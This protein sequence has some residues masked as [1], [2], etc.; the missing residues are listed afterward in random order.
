MHKGPRGH[1]AAASETNPCPPS[2]GNSL[3]YDALHTTWSC[4]HESVVLDI[5]HAHLPPE[6]VRCPAFL[7]LSASLYLWLCLSR[8]APSCVPFRP[9]RPAADKEKETE[10]PPLP[11]LPELPSVAAGGRKSAGGGGGGGGVGGG[12]GGG[13]AVDERRTSLEEM[14]AR[15]EQLTALKSPEHPD[16]GGTGGG[17]ADRGTDD[18]DDDGHGGISAP[19]APGTLLSALYAL[20]EH[21]FFAM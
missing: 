9:P 1:G 15:L 17:G 5:L 4:F 21:G 16:G 8:R 12:I 10:H 11:G 3:F 19:A 13:G 6:S 2:Q 7:L 14:Q 18:D 20:S